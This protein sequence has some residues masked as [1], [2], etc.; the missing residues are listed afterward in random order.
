MLFNLSL[1]PQITIENP[2]L[3]Y[4]ES[5]IS[6][7]EDNIS[8]RITLSWNTY[9][10]LAKISRAEHIQKNSKSKYSEHHS[11]LFSATVTSRGLF[12]KISISNFT[13]SS[14]NIEKITK[15]LKFLRYIFPKTTS[16]KTKEKLQIE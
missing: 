7:T 2:N 15:Y 6:S 12:R 9:W 16:L 5:S 10:Q 8:C 11:C 13:S 14:K 1:D 4:L 3:K